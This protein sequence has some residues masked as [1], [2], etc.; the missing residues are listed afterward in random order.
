MSLMT[1]LR[2]YFKH[3]CLQDNQ[4]VKKLKGSNNISYVTMFL[5]LS[6]NNV[7][8]SHVMKQIRLFSKVVLKIHIL[9]K[10]S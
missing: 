6:Y 9:G 10:W 8:T 2:K 3:S 1:S 7:L 5:Q 4:I